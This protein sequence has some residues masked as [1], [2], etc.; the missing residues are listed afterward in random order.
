MGTSP[1]AWLIAARLRLACTLL[2][3]GDLT[4]EEIARRSG[5]GSAANLRLQFRR[6]YATTPL[7]YRAAFQHR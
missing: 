3:S 4:V 1:R 6:A 5:L 7:A 2:E